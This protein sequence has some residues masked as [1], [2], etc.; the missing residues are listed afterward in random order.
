MGYV[1]RILEEGTFLPILPY[2]ELLSGREICEGRKEG[3]GRQT[4][5]KE[6]G[7]K[8]GGPRL[9]R[10]FSV[11]VFVFVG[12]SS[13]F[14]QRRM[15]RE[16]TRLELLRK[17]RRSLARSFVCSLA[18]RRR[19]TATTNGA[20]TRNGGADGRAQ[21]THRE[22]AFRPPSVRPSVRV[23]SPA[24]EKERRRP[25]EMPSTAHHIRTVLPF[26]YFN[27]VQSALPLLTPIW[28]DPCLEFE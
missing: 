18:G 14:R 9:R 20:P 26:L 1:T 28:P 4:F 25:E 6:E 24:A 3:S 7:R 13:L 5:D 21:R 10:L 11:S 12:P 15:E 23:R 19:S 16:E 8:E 17:R 22:T 2:R 27:S